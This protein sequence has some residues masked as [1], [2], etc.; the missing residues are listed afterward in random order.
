MSEWDYETE[1]QKTK[2]EELITPKNCGEKLRLVREVSGLSRRDLANSLG[3]SESTISR[4]E[5]EKTEPTIDFTNRLRALVLIGYHRFAKMSDSQKGSLSENISSLGGAAAGI[6]GAIGT[7]SA[8]QT[9]SGLDRLEQ[10]EV[11]VL[12]C[13][14][15]A[16]RAVVG[17]NDHW[18]LILVRIQAIV[19]FVPQ[20]DDRVVAI[21]P[22][23]RVLDRHHKFLNFHIT[24]LDQGW[25]Q[26]GLRAIIVRVI[27]AERAGI[28]ASVLVVAL[29]RRNEGERRYLAGAEIGV[30]TL[31]SVKADDLCQAQTF[32][33]PLLN[34]LEIDERIMLAGIKIGQIA[35]FQW[36]L[37]SA[38]IRLVGIDRKSV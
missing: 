28:A 35:R 21:R 5:T 1:E 12:Y 8:G 18:H 16:T 24:A 9:E 37:D 30:Q 29:V 20:H 11:V 14:L 27:V 33:Q 17:H 10:G 26:A 23:R 38:E 32:V 6:A 2:M 4:L 25:I 13:T 34:T 3:C 22:G 31:G 7:V 19:V 36:W 15:L